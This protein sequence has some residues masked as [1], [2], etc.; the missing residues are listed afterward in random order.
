MEREIM[1]IFEQIDEVEDS[2]WLGGGGRRWAPRGTPSKIQ[3]RRL[4]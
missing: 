4:V 3:Q 1:I 2:A